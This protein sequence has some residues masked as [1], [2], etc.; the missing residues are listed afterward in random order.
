VKETGTAI[1]GHGNGPLRASAGTAGLTVL[2]E[3]WQ[4]VRGETLSVWQRLDAQR[5]S[6][7]SRSGDT[8]FRSSN[9]NSSVATS[10]IGIKTQINAPL[11]ATLH[12]EFH[13]R[14]IN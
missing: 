3:G 5:N 4:T 11:H 6:P 7:A 10:D 2:R 8:P 9:T 12:A 13:S 14:L 1:P